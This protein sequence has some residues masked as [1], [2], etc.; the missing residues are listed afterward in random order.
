[1]P[2]KIKAVALSDSEDEES[3]AQDELVRKRIRLIQELSELERPSEKFTGGIVVSSESGSN[4]HST[5]ASLSATE[6]K[7]LKEVE[8]L[9]RE[10][11]LKNTFSKETNRRDEDAEMNKY[12]DEQIRLRREAAKMKE[13]QRHL[14]DDTSSNNKDP[15]LSEMFTLPATTTDRVDDILLETLSKNYSSTTDEKS[16]AMLSSQMLTGIPEV[17]LGMS[18][19][20]RTIEATEEAKLRL[21]S[22][23]SSRQHQ[24]TKQTSTVPT[25]YSTNY[26]YHRSTRDPKNDHNCLS[27]SSSAHSEPKTITEPVVSIGEQPK[28]I[29]Y[30]APTTNSGERPPPAKGRASDDYYLQKF[31]KNSRR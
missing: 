1:M 17:D 29:E 24:S 9:E 28:E 18:E 20:I 3:E 7:G 11:D 21:L 22:K 5:S 8:E 19:R 15:E 25:N 23:S 16:E 12:I 4:V 26:H 10:L 30:R 31:K 6:K 2:L 14:N 27:K 13:K